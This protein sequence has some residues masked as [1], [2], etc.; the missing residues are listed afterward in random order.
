[1]IFNQDVGKAKAGP[2]VEAS[3]TVAHTLLHV[4]PVGT[5]LYLD[6]VKGQ[7]TQRRFFLAFLFCP[8]NYRSIIVAYVTIS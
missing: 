7:E 5:A 6:C 4:I 1:M 3:Q 8:Q 2:L